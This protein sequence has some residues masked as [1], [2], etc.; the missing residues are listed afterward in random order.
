MIFNVIRRPG[1]SSRAI[2]K[3]IKDHNLT[4]EGFPRE[5]YVTNPSQEKDTM[6]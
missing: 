6:K 3:L 1:I 5:E 2:Q 4:S